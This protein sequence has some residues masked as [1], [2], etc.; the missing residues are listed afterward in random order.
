VVVGDQIMCAPTAQLF[1]DIRTKLNDGWTA[2]RDG[3][4]A[5]GTTG[6]AGTATATGSSPGVNGTPG[7]ILVTATVSGT[8]LSTRYQ[9]G[10]RIKWLESGVE[11][12]GTVKSVAYASSVTTITLFETSLSA[13]LITA[14]PD[15]SLIWWSYEASPKGYPGWFPFNAAF[16]GVSAYPASVVNR[17]RVIGNH[18]WVSHEPSSTFTSNSGSKS[19]QGPV[20][21]GSSMNNGGNWWYATD[22]NVALTAAGSVNAVNASTAINMYKDCSQAAWTTSGN[23]RAVFTINYEY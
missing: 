3:T 15:N 18:I 21:A 14:N 9:K 7:T 6:T 13:G 1:N 22:N 19:L 12:F 11:K 16:T 4:A 17:Y 8:D 2:E 23:W 10:T 20:T 5:K